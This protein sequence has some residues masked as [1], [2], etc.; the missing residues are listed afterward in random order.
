MLSYYESFLRKEIYPE[1]E[2]KIDIILNAYESNYS[3]ARYIQLV[4]D[5]YVSGGSAYQVRKRLERNI[6]APYKKWHKK[7][8]YLDQEFASKLN[9]RR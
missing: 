4:I 7:A 1:N 5:D 9:E 6:I 8:E 3:D 2:E